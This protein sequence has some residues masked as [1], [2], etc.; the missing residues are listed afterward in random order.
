MTEYKTK[1]M[2][3][4]SDTAYEAIN[5]FSNL[6]EGIEVIYMGNV[7]GGPSIGSA[8]KVMKIYARKA[9]VDMGSLGT[10]NVPYC[11]L[12]SAAA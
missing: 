4:N 7:L 5:D 8:G 12:A 6:N 10:W 2:F 1:N 3:E 11:F 9:L